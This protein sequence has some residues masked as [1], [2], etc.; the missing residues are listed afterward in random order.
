MC[1]CYSAWLKWQLGY[2]DEAASRAH[3][4]VA[5]ATELNHP[6]SMGE[7]YGFCT[8]VHHFRGESDVALRNAERAIQI[9]EEGSFAVWL[10]HAKLM[11]GRILAELGDPLEGIEEMRQAYA[12]WSA[13]GAV[14]TRPFYLAQQAEGLGLAGRPDE[15]LSLLETAYDIV[16][17]Y[18]ERYH[19]AEIRRLI[20]EFILQSGRLKGRGRIEDAERWFAGALEVARSRQ[21]HSMEL[22]SA[23]SLARLLLTQGRA[24]EAVRILEPAYRWFTEGRNTG[25]LVRAQMLLEELR[26]AA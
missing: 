4:V 10:A 20:G 9:C 26:A 25:D 21:F 8:A 3:R 17:R 16:R 11:H 5:L 24:R 12:M 19:E 14:V 1:L 23:T 22:R 18:G 7:A 15:A 2:P 13:T 6:F